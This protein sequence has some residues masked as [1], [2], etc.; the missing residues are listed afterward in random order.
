MTKVARL[1]AVE[2]AL[3]EVVGV[4]PADGMRELR[5]VMADQGDGYRVALT[6]AELVE[7]IA[8][9]DPA[10]S[11]AAPPREDEA[12]RPSERLHGQC[13]TCGDWLPLTVAMHAHRDGYGA[14]CA[15]SD[16]DPVQVIPS[17]HELSAGTVR[18]PERE[19]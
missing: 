13:D 15:G 9:N 19:S 18:D 10:P 3:R 12:A 16:R 4:E 14:S 7:E 1:D 6:A 2:R 5:F 17:P 8:A 11:V